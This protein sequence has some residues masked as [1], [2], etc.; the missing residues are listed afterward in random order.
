MHGNIFA[1]SWKF[2]RTFRLAISSK[3]VSFQDL[4]A[5]YQTWLHVCWEYH[6][7]PTQQRVLVQAF[8]LPTPRWFHFKQPA[9][10]ML[11]SN[12]CDNWQLSFQSRTLHIVVLER[13]M[14]IIQHIIEP[15]CNQWWWLGH[16]SWA[17]LR[18]RW[19]WQR[20][21]PWNQAMGLLPLM[22][23]PLTLHSTKIIQSSLSHLKKHWNF[24]A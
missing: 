7:M 14:Q 19:S 11:W 1:N 3:C 5:K 13:A 12:M 6:I 21:G 24:P 17:V 8:P 18:G 9:V 23:G 22:S 4:G 10:D 20:R 16:G 2:S 15:Q